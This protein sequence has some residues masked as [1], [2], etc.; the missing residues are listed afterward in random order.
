M[1][2]GGLDARDPAL[3]RSI[4]TV[5][6]RR[7]GTIR[8][9]LARRLE[10]GMPKR[11]GMLEWTLI[12]AAAQILFLDA[13]DHAAVDLAVKATRAEPASAPFAALANAVLRDDRARA[14]IRSSPIPIPFDDDT[15]A[16]LAARWRANYGEGLAREIASANRCEPTLDISVKSDAAGWARR[17]GGLALPTGSVRLD[18]HEAVAGLEGYSDGEWWVQD[19]AAALPAR[20]LGARAGMRV[21]DLCAAPGG[22]SAEL[23]AAGAAVTTVD[24]SAERLKLLAANFE[25]L[26]LHSEIVVAD[27]LAFDAPPFDGVLLDAPCMATGTI[28][29]HPDVAWTKRHGDLAPLV[30]LQAQL[31]DKA[32]AL[33]RR[34]RNDR[35]LRVLARARGGR[36]PD[37][38]AAAPQSRRA[39]LARRPSGDRRPRRMPDARRATCALC[40][41][42]SGAKTPGAP[43]S[44]ASSPRGSPRR[45]SCQ[46]AFGGRSESLEREQRMLARAAV[47]PDPFRSGDR[48]VLGLV[49]EVP[50][51]VARRQRYRRNGWA[52]TVRAP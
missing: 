8:K 41:A 20:L 1:R 37:R 19:A 44:T 12:A 36:G 40:P 10:K 4:A 51:T 7:L 16:W 48:P 29:R 21:V 23:A 33:T 52:R 18:T 14:R 13:P 45:R 6:L 15:P 39:A 34:R 35:L 32:I 47:F 11:S 9:A 2:A 5:A 49:V 24:R 46:P 26:R 30:K 27:A 3:A 28:R 22:K 17:L 25:R 42:I 31:L 50:G 38:L 43:A